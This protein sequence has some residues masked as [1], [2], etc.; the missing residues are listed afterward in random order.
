M[1]SKIIRQIDELGRVVIPKEMRQALN[2]DVGN[3]IE[4]CIRERSIILKKLE[5][6]TT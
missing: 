6:P 3:E 4:I 5:K 2:L 1:D